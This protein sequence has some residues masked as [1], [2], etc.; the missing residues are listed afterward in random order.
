MVVTGDCQRGVSTV[1]DATV[2]LLL[3]GGAIATLVAGSGGLSAV[4]ED[5]RPRANPAAEGATLLATNTASVNYS[6]TPATR[7]PADGVDFHQTE[8]AGFERRAHG[9][10]AGLLADAAVGNATFEGRRL[11]RDGVGFERSVA[12]TVRDRL[13]RPGVR[14]RVVATWEPY[15]DAPVR[16]SVRVG[17]APPR[18]VDVHAATMRVEST[19]PASRERARRAAVD[20]GYAGVA[21]AVAAAVV[22]GRFPPAETRLALRGDYPVDAL[23]VQRYRRTGSVLGVQLQ[24][25]GGANVSDVNDRLTT[26]LAGRLEA[27]LAE[28]YSSPAAAADDVETATVRVTVRTWS[29]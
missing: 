6:L 16:G 15:P 9:T 8:G 10:L 26:A 18:N 1:V 4:E 25:D 24:V 5:P 12:A 28:R 7:S 11:S 27:D 22:R 13:D 2:F 21:R 17:E 3:V 23:T 14:T 29:P 19:V 20:D